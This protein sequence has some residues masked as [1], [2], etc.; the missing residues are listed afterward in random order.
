VVNGA[1]LGVRHTLDSEL[2]DGDRIL[3]FGQYMGG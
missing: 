3:L 2:R 1:I